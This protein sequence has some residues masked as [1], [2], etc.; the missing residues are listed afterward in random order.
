MSQIKVLLTV[1]DGDTEPNTKEVTLVLENI[2]GAWKVYRSAVDT[3][4]PDIPGI[5]VPLFG[6]VADWIGKNLA[7]RRLSEKEV[8]EVALRTVLERMDPD[9]INA[10]AK[11]LVAHLKF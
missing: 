7:G 3:A 6:A 11:A 1:I 9:Q 5:G 4:H 10:L 2:P 8:C